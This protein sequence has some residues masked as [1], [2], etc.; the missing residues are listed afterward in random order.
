MRNYR[1]KQSMV[2][3][4]AV[5]FFVGCAEKEPTEEIVAAEGDAQEADSYV[6]FVPELDL[7]TYFSEESL[8]SDEKL[9]TQVNADVV[10]T[11]KDGAVWQIPFLYRSSVWHGNPWDH[12]S[13]LYVPTT[14]NPERAGTIAIIQQGTDDLDPGIDQDGQFG[15]DTA[16]ALGIPVAVLGKVPY[17]TLFNSVESDFLSSTYSECFEAFLVEADL[18]NCARKLT[19]GEGK[20]AF[21]W[22]LETPI[23][24]A[25]A[26]SIKAI[27]LMPQT[28]AGLEP[29]LEGAPSF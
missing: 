17:P 16:I 7:Y 2:M 13:V 14:L 18:E 1:K 26:R 23:V 4:A 8:F 19:W 11:Q 21:S 9:N 28:L 5:L 27:E 24:K 29:P 10:K 22:A 15:V 6:E 25:Y 3:F 20:E 12:P